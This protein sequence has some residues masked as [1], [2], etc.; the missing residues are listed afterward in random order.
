MGTQ[1]FTALSNALHHDTFI[2]NN[3]VKKSTLMWNIKTD[4][5]VSFHSE[6]FPAKT[7]FWKYPTLNTEQCKPTS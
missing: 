7:Q 1:I 6:A 2:Q 4:R 5:N 3:G